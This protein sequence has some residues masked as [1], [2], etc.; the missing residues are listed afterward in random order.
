MGLQ[1]AVATPEQSNLISKC[2]H[3]DMTA[4]ILLCARIPLHSPDV[5]SRAV[6]RAVSRWLPGFEPRSGHMEFVVV[7]VVVGH[8]FS[9]YFC[10]PCHSLHRLIHTHHHN[11]QSRPTPPPSVSAHTEGFCQ[12]ND[13]LRTIR[14]AL[15]PPLRLCLQVVYKM[16][17]ACSTHRG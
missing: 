9:G 7:K 16:G 8:V 2:L 14:A 1:A 11:H 10:F 12:H 17:G 15:L 3:E 5:G 6:A 4:P 13:T